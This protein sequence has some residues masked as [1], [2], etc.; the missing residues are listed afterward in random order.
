MCSKRITEGPEFGVL[1]VLG[2]LGLVVWWFGG[3]ATA[4]VTAVFRTRSPTSSVCAVLARTGFCKGILP[5]KRRF[6]F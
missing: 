1:V 6:S 3:L 5:G 4:A 2:V